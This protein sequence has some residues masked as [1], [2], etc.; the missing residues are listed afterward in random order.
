[1]KIK[2][3]PGM[4]ASKAEGSPPMCDFKG[5][6]DYRR[7]SRGSDDKKIKEEDRSLDL[8]EKPRPLPE[9]PSGTTADCAAKHHLLGGTLQIKPNSY[10]PRPLK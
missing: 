10:H 4:E 7:F 2:P 3:E 5:S 9:V 8:E 1:M 6:P